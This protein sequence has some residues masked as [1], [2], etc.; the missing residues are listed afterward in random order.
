M[1]EQFQ[2]GTWYPIEFA[3]QDG[4]DVLIAGGTFYYDAETFPEDAPF[5]GV[6][7]ANYYQGQ[8]EWHG[9]YGSEYDGVYWHKPTHWMPPPPP[10]ASEER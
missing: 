8:D 9:G 7:V 1:T 4:K 10:P 5:L 3:K 2:F 6:K